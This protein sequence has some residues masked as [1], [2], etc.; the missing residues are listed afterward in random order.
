[1][2]LVVGATGQLGGLIAQTLLD[3]GFQVR[4]LVREGSAYDALMTAGAEPATGDLK[5]PASLLAACAGVDT[6][7]TTANSS[8]R[9]G[10]DTVESVDR[11]GNRNLI[12]AA[13][14]AGVHRFVFVSNLGA[15]PDNPNPFMA[16]KG[17]TEQ[18]LRSSTMSWTIIQP[19]LFMDKMPVLV[20][21]VPALSG[22]P[23]TL[24]GEG[25]RVHS[26]VAMRDVAQYV[27]AVVERPEQDG[28]LLVIG[29]PEP[30]SWRDVVEA[31]ELELGRRIPVQ[32]VPPGQPVAG[33]PDLLIGFLALLETYDSRLDMRDLTGRYG[34]VPTT[35]RAWVHDFVLESAGA[36]A[37]ATETA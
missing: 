19:N 7:V 20:V 21:G 4:I 23:V 12:E 1:M 26:L 24:V 2:I 25:R 16:A 35:L 28:E 18:L 10:A 36:P 34:V 27:L 31:F 8:A 37:G 9:G 33:M 29:G 11:A 30:V 14:S 15:S 13:A 5:D 22:Q 17:E 3:K 6:V 32:T